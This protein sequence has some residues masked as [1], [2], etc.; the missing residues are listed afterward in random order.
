MKLR[1]I[2]TMLA[3]AIAFTFVGCEQPE[4]FL[5]EIKVSKSYISLPVEG[6]DVKIE[7][8][9][10]AD[11]SIVAWD[12]A[13]QVEAE[14][15]EWL[16]VEPASGSKG[17]VEVVF[18]AEATTES[19][20]V[21]LHLNCDGAC[22]VLNVVQITEKAEPEA[23]TCK[24]INE[25]G[26]DGVVY[27]AK[28]VVTL[29]NSS[30]ATYGGFSINDGTATLVVY[31]SDTKG[32]YPDLEVGDEVVVDGPWST[33][34]ANFGNGSQIVSLSKSLIKVEKMSP[35]ELDAAGDVFTVILTNKGEGL[36]VS[37]PE[38]DQAWL[39][40]SGDPLVLGTTT[41][42]ELKA[43]ANSSTPRTTTVSFSTVSGG[44]T[45]TAAVQVSQKGGIPLVSVEEAIA[46]P[47]DSWVMV[48]GIVSGVHKKGVVVTDE[49]GDAIYAYVNTTEDQLGTAL[50]DK[51]NVIGKM[52]SYA[53]FY[54]IVSP[55]I[56]V[57]SSG[58][59]VTYPA[60]VALKDAASFETYKTGTF[61]SIYVE[62]TGVTTGQY[63]DIKIGEWTVSP[64]QTSSAINIA[65]FKDKE[66]KVKGYLVQYKADNILRVLLTS[67]KDANEQ[68]PTI[69]DVRKATAGDEVETMG[70]V[71][72]V[73]QKG[74][75]I[76]DATASIYVYAN[77]VPEVK[78][79]NK[80]TVSGTF[81]NYYG[82]LQI[83]TPVVSANDN[84]TNPVYP[85]PVDLTVQATYDAYA[86]YSKENPTAFDY[87]K[88]KGVLQDDGRT[89]AVGESTKTS[90]LDWSSSDYSALK[91]KTVV[92]TAYI[93]GFHSKGY[94]Q[95]IETSVVEAE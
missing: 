84:G 64:Y 17:K 88:I 62:A 58:N 63:G 68:L 15:P 48:S 12:A 87:V 95:L 77:A 43:L 9:A 10:V 67:V 80:V 72:A 13:K 40:V 91:G 25:N 31:G 82:T 92:V 37:I 93:K 73:H 22:Q 53:N 50:G 32:T 89:I 24:W 71:M 47:A 51:V 46:M 29:V 7:V 59:K 75:I 42:V 90:Q 5:D 8:D 23:K 6:G 35:A 81:D 49:A 39:S 60:P 74:Y 65:D 56:E 30:Y 28:G 61:S 21:V 78:V 26:E 76:S 20:E 85:T 4:Q 83:K 33:K 1:N 18:S 38:A 57:L 41:T 11:W 52:G 45:Y 34:Y 3:A 36:T 19:K 54:Q 66:V 86:T 69:A 27:R 79:G 16:T 55:E 2:F 94:Y 14:I 70:T 44:K